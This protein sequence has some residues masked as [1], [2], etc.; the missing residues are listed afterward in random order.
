MPGSA[1]VI[2]ALGPGLERAP[3]PISGPRR[4]ADGSQVT[5]RGLGDRGIADC[6]VLF[7]GALEAEGAGFQFEC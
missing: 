5:R 7:V 6:K 3:A 2:A 4:V 1:P